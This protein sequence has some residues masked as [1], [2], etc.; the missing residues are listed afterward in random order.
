MKLTVENCPIGYC[1]CEDHCI[2]LDLV[3]DSENEIE[4]F[5]SALR[6]LV[7]AIQRYDDNPN[8]MISHAAYNVALK[9]ALSVL[10]SD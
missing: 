5:R 4:K 6:S 7:F 9:E 8:S 3:E 2:A 1:Q 10:E